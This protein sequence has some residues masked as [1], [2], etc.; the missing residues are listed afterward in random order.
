M[1]DN[2]YLFF[3]GSALIAQI[4]YLWR[5]K[6]ELRSH[7]FGPLRLV[8][9]LTTPGYGMPEMREFIISFCASGPS[10]TRGGRALI[11]S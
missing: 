10:T 8:S 9:V 3:D 4:R 11:M 1:A 6:P 5:E 7:K 2:T